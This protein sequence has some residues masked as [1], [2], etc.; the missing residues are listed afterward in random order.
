M[1][2]PLLEV[3][4]ISVQYGGV[5]ALAHVSLQIHEQEIVALMGPN[6]AGKST[7]LKSMFGMAPLSSG[8]I[9]FKGAAIHPEPSRMVRSGIS[10]V[11]QG[12]RVFSRLTIQENLE[13][14]GMS[15]CKGAELKERIAEVMELFPVLAHRRRSHAGTL[16]GGQQQML[17]LARGLVLRPILLLLDEPTLGLSPLLVK[18]VFLK[19]KEIHDALHTTVVVVEHNLKSLLAIV[20][21]AYI[22][23][24]GS[25]VADG[26]VA[27]L[28]Q[29]KILEKV[30]LGTL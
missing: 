19:V 28:K 10:F 13:I 15:V 14:G 6:G 25:L 17:A 30:M 23:D 7:V 20:D 5:Q 18:E 27:S 16:S 4:D 8:E 1:N 21:R 29:K 24:K 9:L 2:T 12:R 22:L 11:P 26:D 3:K